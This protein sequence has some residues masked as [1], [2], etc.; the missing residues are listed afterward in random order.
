MKERRKGERFDIRLELTITSLF[1]QDYEIIPDMNEGIEVRNISKSGI[2][3]FCIHELPMNYYFDAK[4]QLTPDKYFYAVLKIIRRE[5]L[6]GGYFVGCE[7]VGLA[8]VLS[9]KVDQYGNDRKSSVS[10]C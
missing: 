5:K 10:K 1:K 7:F 6:E 3:F 4:I 2:G 9:M 8:D